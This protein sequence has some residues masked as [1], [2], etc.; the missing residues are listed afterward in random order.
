MESKYIYIQPG[1]V[2]YAGHATFVFAGTT[3]SSFSDLH[4]V[5]GNVI[6]IVPGGESS[7]DEGDVLFPVANENNVLDEDLVRF[8]KKKGY[9]Y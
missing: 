1:T 5:G 2:D 4:S 7:E 8:Y 3:T 6:T 9:K